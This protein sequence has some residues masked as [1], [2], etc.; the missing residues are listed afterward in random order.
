MDIEFLTCIRLIKIFHL[1][2]YLQNQNNHDKAIRR[3]DLKDQLDLDVSCSHGTKKIAWSGKMSG[4]SI[5]LFTFSQC[6]LKSEK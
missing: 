1:K 2:K 3:R 4:G 6:R 5:I